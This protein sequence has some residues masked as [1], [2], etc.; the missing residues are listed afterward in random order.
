MPFSGIISDKID[1]LLA[2]NKTAFCRDSVTKFSGEN[3]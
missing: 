1:E 3:S 2:K